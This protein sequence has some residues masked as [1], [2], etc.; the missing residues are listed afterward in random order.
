MKMTYVLIGLVLIAGLVFYISSCKNKSSA[1]KNKSTEQQT[2]DTSQLKKV[3]PNNNP[4]QDLRN[5]ALGA[6]MEQIGVQ[7]PPDQTKIYGVIMDWD[8][9]EGTA[10]LVAFLSGDASLYLSSGGG[11]IG[12]S[13]HDN[14]KQAAAAF[15]KKADEYLSKTSKTHSTP[16]PGKDGVKFYFLTNKGKFVGQ[17]EVQ[18]FDNNSSPWLDLFE[19]GNKLITEIRMVSD[20]K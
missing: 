8:V 14:V 15:I 1:D 2:N 18:N 3:D 13:G 10:T 9:G 16:L 17:E 4:Y 12:G 11:V 20:M 5:L 19:E 7:F 6:T